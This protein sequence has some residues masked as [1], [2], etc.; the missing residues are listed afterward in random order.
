[1]VAQ[2]KEISKISIMEIDEWICRL[3][4]TY[5]QHFRFFKYARRTQLSYTIVLDSTKKIIIYF[6]KELSF[7][8]KV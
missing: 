7:I 2:F 8:L 1:M 6:D 4:N 5:I 3:W